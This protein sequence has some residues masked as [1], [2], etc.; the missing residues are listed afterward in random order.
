MKSA[1]RE[2]YERYMAKIEEELAGC[3]DAERKAVLEQNLEIERALLARL[4][5]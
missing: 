3:E 2:S 4:E 5:Q 1:I